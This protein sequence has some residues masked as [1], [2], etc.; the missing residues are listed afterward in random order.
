M[1]AV[2]PKSVT[3]EQIYIGIVPFVLLQLMGLGMVMAFPE[4]AL[5]LPRMLLN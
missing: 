3:I 4:I 2:A 5:W 1:K